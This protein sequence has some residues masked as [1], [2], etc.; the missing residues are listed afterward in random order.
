[1]PVA[2]CGRILSALITPS[3]ADREAGR[4]QRETIRQL[5]PGLL[6]FP[7]NPTSLGDRATKLLRRTRSSLTRRLKR[8]LPADLVQRLRGH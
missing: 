6:R 3:V 7:I 1:M 8:I 2:N 5:A 4:L